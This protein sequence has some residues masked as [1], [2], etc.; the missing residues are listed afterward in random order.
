MESLYKVF[1]FFASSSSE[2]EDY[3]DI[4]IEEN[5]CGYVSVLTLIFSIITCFVFYIIIGRITTS[6]QKIGHWIFFALI[7]GV[8]GF[9]IAYLNVKGNLYPG[10]P[11]ENFGLMFSMSNII[12]P[13]IYFILFSFLF[14]HF[15]LYARRTPI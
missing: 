4:L 9:V 3:Y 2:W 13:I 12:W 8:I 14:K 15:S 5:L 10:I 11:V 7:S 6:F 1:F